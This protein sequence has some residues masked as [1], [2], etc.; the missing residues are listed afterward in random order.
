[1]L[2]LIT[3]LFDGRARPTSANARRTRSGTF[4]S[5]RRALAP[6]RTTKLALSRNHRR[7]RGRKHHPDASL[8]GALPH[9]RR[10]LGL[11]LPPV[12]PATSAPGLRASRPHRRRDC[13]HPCHICTGTALT[14]ATS[15][16]G[17]SPPLP[18]LYWDWAHP[19]HI[20][21]TVGLTPPACLAHLRRGCAGL[22]V[23]GEPARDAC[24]ARRPPIHRDGL[25]ALEAGAGPR[26]MR[27]RSPESR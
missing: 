9:L 19:C 13:A 26:H 1:M 7:T 8:Y 11:P 12:A 14:P 25:R 16:P 24:A 5:T 18:R 10:D 15:A 6:T 2:P 17:L 21:T 4:R 23:A 20:G 3:V 22:A 27:K